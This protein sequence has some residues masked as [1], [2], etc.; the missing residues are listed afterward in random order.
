MMQKPEIKKQLDRRKME[1]K[2]GKKVTPQRSV[3]YGPEG[4]GKSALAATFPNPVFIDA[5]QGTSHMDVS[6]FEPQSMKEI[7]DSIRFLRKEDH[8]FKTVILDTIDWVEK[9]MADAI[10][11]RHNVDSI[12]KV[13]NGYGKGYTILEEDMMDFLASLDSL[14]QN[15]GMEIVLLAH[16]KILRYEDP[17]LAASYDRHQLKMEKKTSALVKEWTDALIFFN[18]ETK[19]TDRAGTMNSKR[20]V[21]GKKRFL[22][23]EREAA[24]DAKNRMNLPEK[25]LVPELGAFPDELNSLFEF[26]LN[27]S[28]GKLKNSTKAVKAQSDESIDDDP[29]GE[30]DSVIEQCGG[31]QVVSEFLE[32]RDLSLDSLDESYV[33]RVLTSQNQ[34]INQVKEYTAK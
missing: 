18:F 27:E 26:S 2:T 32:S 11:S 15:R 23:C 7:T 1:L 5:E 12:E 22:R 16:S 4:V 17:E 19:V 3:F 8:K 14:R 28:N 24:F 13:E 30:L 9:R 21:G 29:W 25:I 34:F 6:R 10:C 33:R 31:R 20:G